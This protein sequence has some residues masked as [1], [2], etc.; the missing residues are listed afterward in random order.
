MRERPSWDEYFV[1]IAKDVASRAT[2]LRRHVGAVIVKDK[3]ILTTGYNGAPMGLAHCDD[4]GCHMVNGHCVRCL[5]AEQN[6]IIQGALFGVSTAGATIYCTDQP[7]T[8]CAKMIVNAGIVRIVAARHYPDEYALEVIR[9]A[10]ILL[11]YCSIDVEEEIAA[12]A[13][14]DAKPE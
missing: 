12:G 5:H 9:E 3:R 13:S 6:A 10:G 14:G 1:K 8:M 2:C 7:C 4:V 11:E